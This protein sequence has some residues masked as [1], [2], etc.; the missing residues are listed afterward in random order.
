MDMDQRVTL[1]LSGISEYYH[2]ITES[3]ALLLSLCFR[4]INPCHYCPV[5]H[6]IVQLQQRTMVIRYNTAIWNMIHG[7]NMAKRRIVHAEVASYLLYVQATL[8]HISSSLH[9]LTKYFT[10]TSGNLYHHLRCLIE[11][12][13]RLRRSDPSIP[14]MSFRYHQQSARHSSTTTRHPPYHQHLIPLFHLPT[15]YLA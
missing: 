2:C 10:L 6:L 5:D 4:L 7:D 12:F 9:H 13:W 14:I 1:P 8:T 3:V 15:I 11:I